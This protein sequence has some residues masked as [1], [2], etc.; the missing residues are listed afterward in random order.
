MNLQKRI[1]EIVH[2]HS[3]G[4]KLIE[5]AT[6]L[7]EEDGHPLMFDMHNVLVCVLADPTLNAHEYV[8][9][10]SPPGT[11]DNGV[12]REKVFIHQI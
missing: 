3:G 9:N 11:D 12:H 1:R 5:L 8:W 2:E 7:T 10:M 4:L 6:L